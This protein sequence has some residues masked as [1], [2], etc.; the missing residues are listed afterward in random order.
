[1]LRCQIQP[2][3]SGD[4]ADDD[5]RAGARLVF[6]GSDSTELAVAATVPTLAAIIRR[7]HG[8]ST[9]AIASSSLLES[10]ADDEWAS[11]AV[12]DAHTAELVMLQL[13]RTLLQPALQASK[14][15]R[16]Q[17]RDSHD[18]GNGRRGGEVSQSRLVADK[19]WIAAFAPE[20]DSQTIHVEFPAIAIQLETVTFTAA[21]PHNAAAIIKALLAQVT[22]PDATRPLLLV[23]GD[24]LNISVLRSGLQV[25]QDE[26]VALSGIQITACVP[27]LAGI[28]A[29]G[30]TRCVFTQ[31][32]QKSAREVSPAR[33]LQPLT[34][35]PE[36]AKAPL[37][38]FG[39]QSPV[40]SLPLH[41]WPFLD[42]VPIALPNIDLHS[43]VGLTVSTMV[44]LG[45]SAGCFAT[46]AL[47]TQPTI[48]R[49]ISVHPVA[50]PS[51][52]G[53]RSAAANCAP[54]GHL[55]QDNLAYM[56]FG[57]LFNLTNAS[58]SGAPRHFPFVQP[59]QWQSVIITPVA[60]EPEFAATATIAELH[61]S[62]ETFSPADRDA[63]V[64]A[65]DQALVAFFSIPR[66]LA[67]GDVFS[68]CIESKQAPQLPGPRHLHFVVNELTAPSSAQPDHSVWVDVERTRLVSHLS[69]QGFACPRF[70]TS[71]LARALCG[72]NWRGSELTRA[73]APVG[74]ADTFSRILELARFTFQ[75]R[76]NS[77]LLV[78]GASG[79]GKS[80]LLSTAAR[81]MGVY[82][83][84]FDC[85]ALASG[86]DVSEAQALQQLTLF[87]DQASDAGPAITVLDHI[88]LLR[89]VERDA[90][91]R[92]QRSGGMAAHASA[93]EAV[94]PAAA[95]LLS[96]WLAQTTTGG[97]KLLIG[98]C[99]GKP[100]SVLNDI[101]DVFVQDL[102]VDLPEMA[103]RQAILS[104]LC[105]ASE[106]APVEDQL[107]SMDEAL[108][109]HLALGAGVSQVVRS[110]V[111]AD[112]DLSAI[113][114]N[115]AGAS[116]R[117][118]CRLVWLATCR[119]TDRFTSLLSNQQIRETSRF[120][121]PTTDGISSHEQ[122]DRA[123]VLSG[124]RLTASDFG[125][126]LG[127]LNSRVVGGAGDAGATASIPNV[128]WDDVG[129]LGAVK[130]DILDTIQLPLQ[131]PELFA[132]GLQ[133]SGLL[134][135]GP[136]G[137]GKTLL[138]KAVAT[139]CSLNFISVKGPELINMY[140]GQSEKNI[141]AVFERARRCKPCVIFFDELDSLAPNR[142]RSG[143][144]GGVMDRIV[145]QLL[146][147][148]DGMQSNTNVF[149]IGATNRP[150]LIDPALL[151]PGRFDRLLYLGISGEPESQEP[152][153]RALTRKFHLDPNLQLLDVARLCPRNF[154]GADLYAV[155]SD[156][157][158]S[159][160]RR[161]IIQL[162]SGA[163]GIDQV[164]PVTVIL[165]DF[166]TAIASIKPS[167]TMAEL[168]RYEQLRDEYASAAAASS[169]SPSGHKN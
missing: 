37:L 13:D 5:D 96:Q 78:H 33:V 21:D 115:T 166:S 27:S 54:V 126:A 24:S 142:G 58:N 95:N 47:A 6:T 31:N 136:P 41:P 117:D 137:T 68:V 112:V 124:L 45:L 111:A 103:Q 143:D 108:I 169:S 99:T 88:H 4:D 90:Q 92:Q 46:I 106:F 9:S 146:A 94:W 26:L 56:S 51:V 158:M 48:T 1:M 80:T 76:Q 84:V 11:G 70:E 98:S 3:R 164:S 93:H 59:D 116:P 30:T 155:C 79:V 123:I 36:P 89:S 17:D 105:T 120:S 49:L 141:R 18:N 52:L 135:Y 156:A 118:L 114:K 62:T 128:T 34:T 40:S 53:L 2:T 67:R 87:L 42:Y 81:A 32:L 154:T 23:Q 72:D 157:M 10:P 148:L 130:R 151:R 83:A 147:E 19:R 74:Q 100:E 140:V 133:R 16:V 161:R 14:A 122:I 132:G 85:R 75:H 162:E 144:S 153:L 152:V 101:R 55:W 43:S 127:A 29:K 25:R 35:R 65:R 159:A 15:S 97:S 64:A 73:C 104:D 60:Q 22:A 145:S 91:V 125:A 138:A 149:V 12:V 7:G 110:R 50:K 134:L 39:L 160:M 168:A 121:S 109:P 163:E 38:H 167:V 165:E 139:E 77:A 131:R 82:L 66:L 63:R 8:Q 129:G 113:A 107:E 150:D 69:A 102:H 61:A 57:L 20:S 28:V 86:S 44:S 119:A 71:Q